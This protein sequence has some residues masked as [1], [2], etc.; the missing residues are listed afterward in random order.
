[1]STSK[2]GGSLARSERTL[3]IC[4]RIVTYA[5]ILISIYPVLFVLLT[6]FKS[7]KEFYNNVWGISMNPQFSNYLTAWNSGHIGEGLATSLLVTVVSLAAILL[8][9]TLGG[10]ALARLKVPFEGVILLLIVITFMLPSE[11]VIM[12]LY[13]LLSKAGIRNGYAMLIIPYIG[14]N[15]PMTI[16]IMRNF[17]LSMPKELIEASRMDGCSE[18]QSLF[19]ISM[20]LMKPA[21]AVSAIF[22]FVGIW[23]D[24][25][26]AQIALSTTS[27]MRTLTMCALSF[28][29]QYGVSWGAMSAAICITIFPLIVFFLFVQKYFVQGITGGAVK[30]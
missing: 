21:M 30:G 1:M 18:M 28:H 13:L 14:W 7:D 4:C 25:L 22:A 8:I 17:F 29:G 15:V 5:L 19:K 12:P 2:N 6:S 26:W 16:T 23:G 11:A 20:P 24:L 10:Y 27:A 3:Q 9:G